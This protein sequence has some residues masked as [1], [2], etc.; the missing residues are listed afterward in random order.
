MKKQ[1]LLFIALVISA[2]AMSQEVINKI[3]AVQIIKERQIYLNGGTR[4]AFGG[5]SREYI[6]VDLPPNTVEW[7]Y[8]FT[9]TPGQSGTKNLNLITQISAALALNANPTGVSLMASGLTKEVLKTVEIPQGSNSADIFL[10]DRT[11]IDKFL[12]KEDQSLLGGSFRYSMEGTVQNTKQAVVQ[13]NDVTKGTVFLGLRNPSGIDGINITI[14]VVALVK[15]EEIVDN[16]EK[17]KKAELYANLGWKQFENGNYQKCV[18]YS[19]KANSYYELGWVYANKGLAQL[20]LNNED[21]AMETY[22]IAITF[23][24]KQQ[25]PKYIFTELIKDL[26]REIMKNP[27]FSSA[28]SIKE[29][30]EMELR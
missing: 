22:V 17:I 8:S 30:M 1:L 5:K 25:N 20:M 13:I 23:I 4:A 19:D 11:N 9:T 18:E 15:K 6:K 29:L 24:K 2:I 28:K 7:Y 21:E 27:N 10:C 26:D 14:E 12:A 16:S 3:E